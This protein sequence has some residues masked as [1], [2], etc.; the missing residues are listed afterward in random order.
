MH[1]IIQNSQKLE[2][3][4]T[5]WK[6]PNNWWMDAQNVILSNNKILWNEEWMNAV[7]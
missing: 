6:Q 7:T 5:D 3:I 1:S 4:Q 2:T